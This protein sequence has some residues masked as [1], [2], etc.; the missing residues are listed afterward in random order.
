M[1]RLMP[2]TFVA[3]TG[4]FV[5]ITGFPPFGLFLSEFLIILGA[6]QEG[7]YTVLV[8]FILCL[9]LIFAGASRSV[10]RMS[11]GSWD[12]E[13]LIGEKLMRVLPPYFLLAASIALCIWLPDRLYQLIL[14]AVATIGGGIHG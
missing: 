3:F 7:A 2:R 12:G 5:G 13:L 1:A 14:S 6:F 10:I 4:G 11:F 8:L 9:V